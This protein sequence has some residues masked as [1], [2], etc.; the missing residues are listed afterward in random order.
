MTL[1]RLFDTILARANEQN[2]QTCRPTNW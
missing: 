1:V 2:G